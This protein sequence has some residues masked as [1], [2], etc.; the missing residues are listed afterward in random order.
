MSAGVSTSLKRTGMV[1]LTMLSATPALAADVDGFQ[2]SGYLRGGAYSGTPAGGY[3]LGGDLQK[4]RL[5][6]EGDNG[7]EI[8][9]GKSWDAG[10]GMR[11]SMMYMPAVWG[12][13]VFHA[14]AYAMMSGLDFAPEVKFW[15]G[16][17]R[18]RLQEIHI[19]DHFIMDYG[20]STGAGA[21]DINLGFAKLGVAVLNAGDFTTP[22]NANNAHR[23]NFDLSEIQTN[24]G[25]TLRMLAT[26]VQG[27]FEMAAPGSALSLSHDQADFLAT[28]LNNLCSCKARPVM[29]ASPENTR[30]WAMPE[31]AGH[32]PESARCASPM[33][34]TGKA[35]NWAGRRLFPTIVT[36]CRAAARTGKQREISVSAA[37]FPMT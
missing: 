10:N 33:P 8:G 19:V 17:R 9:L 34:S 2:F 11:W 28:G 21:S 32:S 26:V 14:Q 31:T 22:S 29:P 1:I 27:N 16:Q 30:G 4:F 15:A 3:T 20:E 6:N 23:F 37:E 25:G 36:A 13:K 18:S 12:G 35:A 5:G 24:P 7:M